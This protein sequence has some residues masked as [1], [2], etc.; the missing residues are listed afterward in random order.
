MDIRKYIATTEKHYRYRIKSVVML[1]DAA[2]DKIEIILAKYMPNDISA[3]KKTPF[4]SRPLDFKD[5]M[6]AEVWMIDVDLNLPASPYV[7]QQEIFRGLAIPEKFIVVRGEHEPVEIQDEKLS[8]LEAIEAEAAKRG[9]TPASLL[10]DALD[11]PEIE[12]IDGADF[13]GEKRNSQL[14]SYLKKLEDERHEANIVRKD[15]LFGWA[16]VKAVENDDGTFNDDVKDALKAATKGGP[17][18]PALPVRQDTMRKV[19]IDADGNRVV[20]TR[21]IGM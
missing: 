20:L 9:L 6:N 11:F 7:L 15:P 10:D 2:R 13:Y 14:L 17:L 18:P 5:V 12:V 8:A 16:G 21:K 4:Q 19:Y 3:P 1:D